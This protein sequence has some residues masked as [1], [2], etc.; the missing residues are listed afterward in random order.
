M[1]EYVKYSCLIKAKFRWTSPYWKDIEN[2]SVAFS[3]ISSICI[4]K[5]SSNIST[6][7][8]LQKITNYVTV[9]HDNIDSADTPYVCYIRIDMPCS[10]LSTGKMTLTLTLS[11]PIF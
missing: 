5:T 3:L 4:V 9:I 2:K 10:V 11:L 7:I 6:L 1:I 8:I